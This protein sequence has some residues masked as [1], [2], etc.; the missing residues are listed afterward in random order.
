MVLAYK[1]I[2]IFYSD[3]GSG[4][5]VVFLHG[6]MENISMWESLLPSIRKQRRVICIDLLGHGKTGNLGYIHTME[7]MADAVLAVLDY[8]SIKRSIFIGHSMGGY[9]A[10]ALA[11]KKPHRISKL[12]LMN[13][14]WKDDNLERKMNRDRS[15]EA[16]RKSHRVFVNLSIPSL[17]ADK[18]RTL[19]KKELAKIKKEALKISLQGIIAALE[20]MKIRPDY[21]KIAKRLA[22]DK[23]LILGKEDILIDERQLIS[24]AGELG[25]SSLL[26]DGGH[27]SYIENRTEVLLLLAKIVHN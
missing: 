11:A 22:V 2:E 1:G 26:L 3:E 7:M 13:S 12:V 24:Q 4:E 15:V 10:L 19:L 23:Y 25:F 21:T 6:F 17:F 27:M 18:N 20:G 9:V 14:T 16:V 5:S 8:L